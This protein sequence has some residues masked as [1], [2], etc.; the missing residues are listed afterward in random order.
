MTRKSREVVEYEET[1]PT[2][3]IDAEKVVTAYAYGQVCEPYKG[4]EHNLLTAALLCGC[5]SCVSA[6]VE[7]VR[8]LAGGDESVTREIVTSHL[9]PKTYRR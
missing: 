6:Y 9:G 2:A 4:N 7:M 8:F 3:V 1:K 5:H